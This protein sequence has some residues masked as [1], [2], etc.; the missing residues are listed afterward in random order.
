MSPKSPP[1]ITVFDIANWFLAKAKA[2]NQPLKHMK[3]QKLV[4]F[5]YG[6]YCAYRDYSD[7]LF[8]DS[9]F[10]WRRGVIV[11]EL[12]EKFKNFGDSPIEIEGL[13]PPDLNVSV[14]E[15]LEDVWKAYSPL[16]NSLLDSA[17]HRHPAWHTALHSIEWEVVMSPESI[18]ETFKNMMAQYEH[19]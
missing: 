10:V 16:S 5:A 13:Q 1:A 9:I 14:I 6:W 18:R 17:I 12:Y 4:Y 7:P 19:A 11:K 8:A 2:E 15:I 3:L